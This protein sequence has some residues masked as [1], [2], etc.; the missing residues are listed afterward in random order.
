MQYIYDCKKSYNL[1]YLFSDIGTGN[2]VYDVILSM[3]SDASEEVKSAAAFALGS[4]S[5]FSL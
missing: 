2:N 3:F 4:S 1:F 5:F